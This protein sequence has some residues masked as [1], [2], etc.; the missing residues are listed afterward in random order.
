MP[1]TPPITLPDALHEWAEL[2]ASRRGVTVSDYLAELLR[3]EQV[4]AA[5]DRVDA[6][7]LDALDSGPAA[8]MTAQDWQDVRDEG[9]RQAAGRRKTG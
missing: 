4:R 6:K 9:N 8:E 1:Q 5:R 7:L 3:L 2:Q